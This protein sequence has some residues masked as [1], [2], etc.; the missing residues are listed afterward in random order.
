MN[1]E[2]NLRYSKILM[3]NISPSMNIK[4]SLAKIKKIK[5]VMLF[6]YM[7]TTLT[8]STAIFNMPKTKGMMY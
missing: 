1:G 4:R 3:A 8:N 2:K 7:P 5:T 6:T